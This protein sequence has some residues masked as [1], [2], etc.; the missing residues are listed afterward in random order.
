MWD[1]DDIPKG[2][3][4]WADGMFYVFAEKAGE[5]FLCECNPKGFKIKGHFFAEGFADE[6]GWTKELSR[7][8]GTSWAHPVVASGKLYL[9]HF[10]K[11]YCFDVAKK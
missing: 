11:V 7:T 10:D 2:S 8:M 3:T 9:R 1:T 6:S 4:V 5:M